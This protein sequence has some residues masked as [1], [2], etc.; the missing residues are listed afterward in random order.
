MTV[1]ICGFI[2]ARP[3]V[4]DTY[5]CFE[6]LLYS[7]D[8]NLFISLCAIHIMAVPEEIRRI[9][10][11]KNTFVVDS[12]SGIY[13]VREKTGCGY[14]V[15]DDGK[16]HRPSRNGRV[17][18]HIIDGVYVA[19]KTDDGLPPV[20]EVDLKDYANVHLCR[21]RSLDLL[22]SLRRLYN[23]EEAI[24]IYVMAILRACYDGIQ[25]YMLDRQYEET[26]LSEVYPGV[27]LEKSKVSRFLRNLGR[28]GSRI[29]KFMR[30]QV[31]GCEDDD[32]I[33]FDG[34]LKRDESIVNSYSAASRKTSNQKYRHVNV[35]TAYSLKRREQIASRIYPGNM[36]DLRI[37]SDFIDM[38]E[39]TCGLIVADRGFPPE[40]FRIALRGRPGI[41]YLVPLERDRVVIAELHLRELNKVL[42]GTDIAFR[43][44]ESIDEDGEPV[45]Y[46]AFRD[47][48][49]AMDEEARY[50]KQHS[51]EGIDP[52][53]VEELRKEW[54][55]IV[56]ASSRKMEPSFVRKTYADRWMIE[57]SFKFQRSQL[58]DDTTDEES[59]YTVQASQFIDH[60]ASVMASRMR[61]AFLDAGLLEKYTYDQAYSLLLRLKMTRE[62]GGEWKLVR[63]ADKDAQ[64]S[65]V[66]DIIRRPIVPSF[67][68]KRKGRPK[69]SKDKKPR[70]K[71]GKAAGRG[72]KDPVEPIS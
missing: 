24:S 1:S 9:P 16:A 23:E 43:T 32:I 39:L 12:K 20:G 6:G 71:R 58:D 31:D 46:Y 72:L 59:D 18:G 38:V 17:V 25:D 56:F 3:I 68:S 2:R 67:P 45:Y 66:L 49:I 27:N 28:S 52:M 70:K 35:M 44:A 64:A 19:K 8:M 51:V 69:G 48:R 61:N 47:P 26:F 14:Y 21:I 7:T 60:L 41:D 55:T 63:I 50:L 22:D 65:V 11:P 42:P 33:I 34:T 4:S 15:D 10:R 30:E 62:H 40:A 36:V 54:G 37:L 53:R 57:T 29:V 13:S 5:T